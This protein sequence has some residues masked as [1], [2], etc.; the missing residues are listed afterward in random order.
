MIETLRK[1]ANAVLDGSV[2]LKDFLEFLQQNKAA[3]QR[4]AIDDMESKPGKEAAKLLEQYWDWTGLAKTLHDFADNIVNRAQDEYARDDDRALKAVRIASELVRAA[5]MKDGNIHM[6][7]GGVLRRLGRHYDSARE[8]QRALDSISEPAKDAELQ[9]YVICQLA[10]ALRQDK[11]FDEALR[12]FE[13]FLSHPGSGT[14]SVLRPEVL[15]ARAHTLSTLGRPQQAVQS[16]RDA[17]AARRLVTDE[18]CRHWDVESLGLFLFDL[19]Q[20][21]ARGGSL[22]EAR[23]ALAE[24]VELR[25]TGKNKFEY[26]LSL[27]ELGFLCVQLSAE[28][29]GARHLAEAIRIAESGPY[30]VESVEHW[31]AILAVIQGETAL[32]GQFPTPPARISGSNEAFMWNA[33]ATQMIA[34]RQFDLGTEVARKVLDFAMAQAEP[35]L[36]MSARSV[37]AGALMDTERWQE[38]QPE[39]QKIIRI[40]DFI[41]EHRA[42]AT[43]RANLARAYLNNGQ[44]QMAI[45]TLLAGMGILNIALDKAETAQIRQQIMS[46]SL[47]LYEVYAHV[48]A[49]SNSFVQ[50][51][52]ITEHTRAPNLLLWMTAAQRCEQ[53]IA[54]PALRADFEDTLKE[55]RSCE[56]EMDRLGSFYGLTSSE[57]DSFRRRRTAVRERID[58]FFVQ[59]GSAA[60][61]WNSTTA[62]TFSCLQV[63]NDA[64][65]PGT[66]ILALFC[67]NDGIAAAVLRREANEVLTAGGFV[68]WTRSEREKDL[69]PWFAEG[70]ARTEGEIGIGSRELVPTRRVRGAFESQLAIVD[71]RLLKPLLQLISP[72]SPH[73]L[74]VIPHRELAILPYWKLL[75]DC[76]S[77][78]ALTI[79]PSLNALSLCL[80]RKRDIGG[81]TLIVGDQ[82]GTLPQANGEIDFV[83]SV[84]SSY[85]VGAA[86]TPD[87]LIR[88][89]R[90]C[91]LLHIAAHGK[92]DSARPYDSGV[93]MSASSSAAQPF[94]SD[95]ARP[96]ERLTV[97][98]CMAR[99]S[100]PA[101]RLT[102]FSTCES[103]VGS[104][105]AGGE[106][107]GLPN[108]MLVAG[109]K[110]VIAS[111][112]PVH[113]TAAA[114]TMRLFYEIWSGGSG[115]VTSP[116]TALR[117][118]RTRLKALTPE[119]IGNI[120]GA[121]A[122]LPSGKNPFDAPIHSD[123]FCCFGSW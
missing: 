102:I 31:R 83:R 28:K 89:S 119:Q 54:S 12:R 48:A 65:D 79:A 80:S 18:D 113:D 13:E 108:S 115:S 66:V 41:Q 82:T 50:L 109:A 39:Y 43:M 123:A 121:D 122:I 42:S 85:A 15:R 29:E 90:D 59:T 105:H 81:P 71:E 10:E 34:S 104:Q 100:M 69:G 75:D 17:V 93:V 8:L 106:L 49:S 47:V 92:F 2:D 67:T 55:L 110:S 107:I 72:H 94:R 4:P 120:L 84:R 38:A 116:A 24:S 14:L 22:D 99:L 60:L 23:Q 21:A 26:A 101:C 25:K 98:D 58:H 95:V 76:P 74:V 37:I 78:E 11:Q 87:D 56:V 96:A 118:A 77:I 44:G 45:Y 27:S 91:T 33:R 86:S 51:V 114:L 36:E 9:A 103:G 32:T 64:V 70:G 30:N 88:A 3:L 46:A 20:I 40:A 97:A 53:I 6:R 73:R 62:G 19:G 7:C 57:L 16:A 68:R 35:V 1:N 112:W 61:P 5:D 52:D 117:L 63:V 111:L